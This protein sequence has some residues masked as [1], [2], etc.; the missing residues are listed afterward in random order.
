M[1][2][3]DWL[4]FFDVVDK[5]LS[6]DV[7][8]MFECTYDIC[9]LVELIFLEWVIDLNFVVMIILWFCEMVDDTELIVDLLFII[10]YQMVILMDMEEINEVWMRPL[11][12][13]RVGGIGWDV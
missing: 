6:D 1:I 9:F 3:F 13:T 10:A 7:L 5:I 2:N 12:H 4:E 11:K 8:Y